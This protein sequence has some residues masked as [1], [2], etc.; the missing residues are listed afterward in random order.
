MRQA[1]VVRPT[2][3]EETSVAIKFATQFSIP[4]VV[5]G[6]GHSPSGAS[7]SEGGMVID[8]SNLRSVTVDKAVQTVT[9]GGGCTVR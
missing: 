6:G 5:R 4:F 7:A 1:V 9:F 3:S 8:L 2:S